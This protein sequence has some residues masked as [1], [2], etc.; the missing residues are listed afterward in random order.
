MDD[1]Q[2]SGSYNGPVGAGATPLPAPAVSLNPTSLTFAGQTVNTTSAAQTVTLTNSGN[3]PLAISS[4]SLTGTN[5]ADYAQTNTCPLSPSTLAAG[6]NCTISVTFTPTAT[7][8]RSASLSIADNA[9]GSPHAA[10]L[11]GTGIAPG[12]SLIPTSLT[13]TNQ[14]AG[15]TSAAQS[16]TLTNN[17]T[18]ALTISSIGVTGTNSSDFAQTNTCPLSPSTLAVNGTC[19]INV[20]FT[21]TATGSRSA[22]VSI[23]DNA[24]G[25]PQ[26]IA[27]SGTGTSPAVTPS[28]TSLTYAGQTVNTTSAAQTVTLTNSGTAPLTIS[29]IGVTGTN[30]G[31]FAQTNT[32]PLSPSTLAA[33]AN[34]S[35]TVTFTPTATG[36]RSANLAVNDN[37]PGSP[38]T[39]SLSGTGTLAAGTYLTDGFENGL[40]LWTTIGNGSAGTESTTVNSGSFAAALTN[41]SGQYVGLSAGLAGGGLTLTYTRFCFYLPTNTVSIAPLA[42]GRNANG[43]NVW[44]ID[45]DAGSKGLDIYVWNGAGARTDLYTSAN[46]ISASRWYCAEL[47]DSE[48]STGSAQVWLNGTSVASV[49]N[50]DLSTATPYSQLYLW[51][52]TPSST[53]YLDD[54]VVSNAYNGP[55]GSGTAPLA[56]ARSSTM[57]RRTS[58]DSRTL[59][60]PPPV[61]TSATTFSLSSHSFATQAVNSTSAAQAITVTNSGTL[62]SSL[63]S[64]G[65]TGAYPHDFT[66][67]NTCPS[68]LAIGARCTVSVVFKP[69]AKGK[70]TVSLVVNNNPVARPHTIDLTGTG[71]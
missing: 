44:E 3:A 25:S 43:T 71:A 30:A 51:N 40:G 36:S 56:V 62:P 63:T 15:T 37:I 1:V 52:Q 7:G 16:V 21:P 34:C 67:T 24:G 42:Q 23:A 17:G 61:A 65:I 9:T 22:S 55:T 39:V 4:I 59:G 57:A 14:A 46:L 58:S 60:P 11:S 38:Q 27:L 28:P 68:T 10:T 20:T 69:S 31:D 66:Q 41:A 19:T 54:V 13:F 64:I 2:V 32:C 48:T 35:I 47:Q 5:S 50:V 70:R 8:S 53:V 49:S 6:A 45:Y 18:A 26:S 33:G 29:S 12:V